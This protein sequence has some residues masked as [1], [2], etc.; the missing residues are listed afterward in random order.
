MDFCLS[1]HPGTLNLGFHP[2]HSPHKLQWF[3]FL[4]SAAHTNEG[5][6]KEAVDLFLSIFSQIWLF[7]EI[8]A[9]ENYRVI[10][11]LYKPNALAALRLCKHLVSGYT[12]QLEGTY[13][14]IDLKAGNLT[15]LSKLNYCLQNL[16]Y[17]LDRQLSL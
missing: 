1:P 13:A 6:R 14:Q 11:R 8:L 2:S 5:N 9:A 16:L 15:P 10:S 7:T 4:Q 17:F 3:Q 12:F